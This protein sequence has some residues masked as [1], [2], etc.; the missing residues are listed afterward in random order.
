MKFSVVPALAAALV[1]FGSAAFAQ[2]PEGQRQGQQR[3]GRRAQVQV[4]AISGEVLKDAANAPR[5]EFN[6]R[7][8]LFCCDNCKAKFEAMDE[9]GKKKQV[10]VTGLKSRKATLERQLKDVTEQLKKLEPEVA[11]S[12]P[13][14]VVHCMITDEE[15]ASASAAVASV[16]AGGATYYFC[17]AGC[18]TKFDK[19]SD[20]EKA[21]L[22]GIAKNRAAAR[23]K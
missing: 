14:G 7:P 5:V 11:K 9:A 23:A 19:A 3:Q 20:A 17:C 13:A 2:A 22:I 8:V 12:A 15:I 21:K 1:L 4:C 6:G 16:E 18:K 10:Q